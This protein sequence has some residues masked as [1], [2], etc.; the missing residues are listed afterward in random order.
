MR[1]CVRA[2][3]RVC[4]R[5]RVCVL[6]LLLLLLG[7]CC[8]CCCCFLSFFLFMKSRNQKEGKKK[9]KTT[10]GGV[11]LP[12][13]FICRESPRAYSGLMSPF[14]IRQSATLQMSGNRGKS[15]SPQNGV[16]DKVIIFIFLHN[17]LGHIWRRATWRCNTVIQANLTTCCEP[18][19]P[20]TGSSA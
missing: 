17:K 15:G 19:Y 7:F 9:R 10:A 13:V 20:V 11:P 2:C 6:L 8:C 3:V 18:G 14:E 4:V 12:H 5:V 1:A 16:Y